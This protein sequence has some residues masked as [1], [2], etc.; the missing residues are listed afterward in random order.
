MSNTPHEIHDEFPEFADKIHALKVSDEQFAK[1]LED[2]RDVNRTIHRAETEVEPLGDVEMENMRKQ[3][4]VLKDEIYG[5][6]TKA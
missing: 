5:M 4:M 1:L 3:R 2:Y 6:L